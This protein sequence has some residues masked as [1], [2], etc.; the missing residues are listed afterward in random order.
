[1]N[2]CLYPNF[3]AERVRKGLSQQELAE[4][5]GC[6]RK[7]YN[8]WIK[9]GNIPTGMLIKFADLYGVSIDYLLNREKAQ[10]RSHGATRRNQ[11]REGA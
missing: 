2:T 5:V 7:S 8:N 6:C 11:R 9:A 4:K 10:S 1:M 3:E